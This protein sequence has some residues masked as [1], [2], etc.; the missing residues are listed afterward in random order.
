MKTRRI[1]SAKAFPLAV[2]SGCLASLLLPGYG[3]ESLFLARACYTFLLS[4][5]L[6]LIAEKR[7]P[8]CAFVFPAALFFCI[9]TIWKSPVAFKADGI[10]MAI[11]ALFVIW[12]SRFLALGELMAAFVFGFFYWTETLRL[13]GKASGLSTLA[14]I[15]AALLF[16]TVF[17]QNAARYNAQKSVQH[18]S[19][20][21]L[22]GNLIPRLDKSWRTTSPS[23][24]WAFL[25]AALHIII[26]FF[27][28]LF[29]N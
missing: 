27:G 2:G 3:M 10:L 26:V 5:G 11:G 25:V 28:I 16:L 15:S 19:L 17:L 22:L 9:L 12:P 6:A 24:A 23:P 29:I 14:L 13:A 21:V 1:H 4:L 20:P 8:A 18:F 7:A